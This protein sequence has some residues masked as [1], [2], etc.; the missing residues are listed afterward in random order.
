MKNIKS[1]CIDCITLGI[2]KALMASNYGLSTLNHKC[3]IFNEFYGYKYVHAGSVE[4][5][6]L[7]KLFKPLHWKERLKI[8]WDE[9]INH[10][11]C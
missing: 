4:R 10:E 3:S 1:P 8:G 5:I 6:F 11:E 2:C 7:L 9:V